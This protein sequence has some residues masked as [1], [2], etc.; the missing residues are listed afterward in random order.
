VGGDLKNQAAATE[1]LD[2]EGIEDWM[3]V[4]SL[5][6]NIDNST[7]DS[8]DMANSSLRLGRV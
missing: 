8:L 4:T 5:E 2:L 6:L 7:N 1:V 3:Q